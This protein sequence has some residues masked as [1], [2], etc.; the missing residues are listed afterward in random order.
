MISANPWARASEALG[1]ELLPCSRAEVIHTADDAFLELIEQR[2]WLPELFA[3]LTTAYRHD[4]QEKK[5]HDKDACWSSLWV[6]DV[7]H[8]TV[9]DFKGLERPAVVLAVDGFHDG[10]IPAQVM[11]AGMS[12]A[13]DL[14]IVV[15][16]P[17]GIEE[18]VGPAVMNRHLDRARQ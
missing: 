10:V 9:A 3:L 5:E 6:D 17:A 13:R 18:A 15:A 8:G 4:L 12:R 16:E 7:F 2:G 1:V 14:L 11:Y